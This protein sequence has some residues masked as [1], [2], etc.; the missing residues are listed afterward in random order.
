ME[1]ELEELDEED[2]LELV[3]L[4]TVLLE[5]L[6]VVLL[7]GAL[8]LTVHLSSQVPHS[9]LQIP[10]QYCQFQFWAGFFWQVNQV[11]MTLE[12]R[13]NFCGVRQAPKDLTKFPDLSMV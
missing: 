11:R 13:S 12:L 8:L 10:F 5:V 9:F 2:E 7:L 6:L 1:E 4:V 3:L